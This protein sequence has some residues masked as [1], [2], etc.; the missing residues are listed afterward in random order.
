MTSDHLYKPM[1]IHALPITTI[2]LLAL[3]CH[4]TDEIDDERGSEDSSGTTMSTTESPDSN[5]ADG[6]D[7]ADSADET[8]ELPPSGPCEDA[9]PPQSDQ[10][11]TPTELRTWD[12]NVGIVSVAVDNGGNRFIAGRYAN[13]ITFGDQVMQAE[14]ESSQFVAALT[15]D[16]E[17]SWFHELSG[18]RAFVR[19]VDVDQDGAVY[20]SGVFSTQVF[21]DGDLLG[22][23]PGMTSLSDFPMFAKLDGTTGQLVWFRTMTAEGA[24]SDSPH[25][26]P[27]DDG[28]LLFS[29]AHRSGLWTFGNDAPFGTPFG[30]TLA[31]IDGDGGLAWRIPI[32][33][34]L[35]GFV[36]SAGIV[37]V[38]GLYVGAVATRDEPAMMSITVDGEQL[39][40]EHDVTSYLVHVDANGEVVD[41]EVVAATS[42]L[43][44]RA[45]AATTCSDLI[46]AGAS[47]SSVDIGGGEIAPGMFVLR[48][49]LDGSHRWSVTTGLGYV[50]DLVMD[51]YGQPTIRSGDRLTTLS[52]SGE[53]LWSLDYDIGSMS[54]GALDPTGGFV[55]VGDFWTLDIPPLPAMPFD[56]IPR[57]HM[58][59]LAP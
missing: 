5:P 32:Q 8:G 10:T 41:S 26:L 45:I 52:A 19:T 28:G 53:L 22:D 35:G 40:N 55:L 2:I 39:S 36:E 29:V 57:G 56:G 31:K 14:S 43:Q 6:A 18:E 1:S 37:A 50:S 46:L 25:I 48:R 54:G 4:P 9:P 16:G 13:T 3:A 49:A 44:V 15:P 17:L 27:L 7:S 51:G 34:S 58:I 11:G 24:N 12:A 33:A 47:T 20:L 59:D 23:A 30:V 21:F 42:D 38:D